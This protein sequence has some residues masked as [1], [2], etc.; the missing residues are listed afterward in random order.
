MS[1]LRYEFHACIQYDKWGLTIALYRG[2][3]KLYVYVQAMQIE[4]IMDTFPVFYSMQLQSERG[5]VDQRSRR[6][7]REFP[8]SPVETKDPNR[9]PNSETG[10]GTDLNHQGIRIRIFL[11]G[12][13]SDPGDLC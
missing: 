5:I 9:S 1:F 4:A 2:T 7:P 8:G 3:I 6:I 11:F 12:L 13:I 10:H